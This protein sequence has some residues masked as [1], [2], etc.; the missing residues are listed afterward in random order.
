MTDT[1]NQ[2][3]PPTMTVRK[4]YASAKGAQLDEVME[5]EIDGEVFATRPH[6]VGVTKLIDF[7]GITVTRDPEAMW[8][9]FRASMGDDFERFEEFCN[10]P[11]HVIEA[12]TLGDII[13]DMV[14]FTTGRPT[15]QSNS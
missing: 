9:F 1:L 14:E 3:A 11:E 6:R 5:I 12:E 10:S 8:G 4:S 15:E 2:E 7:Q 13:K